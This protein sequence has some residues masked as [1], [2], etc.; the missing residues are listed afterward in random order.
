[1]TNRPDKLDLDIKRAGRLDKKIPL[2]YAQTADEVEA[3]VSAQL[4]KH[5]L[6]ST[7]AFPADRAV[8]SEP[9]LGLSNADFEAIVLLA[10]EIAS[11]ADGSSVKVGREQMVQAIADYLPS[12]DVK[13]LEYMEL[14]AVFE[15]SNRKML[16]LK[17]QTM[18]AEELQ[19][20]LELLRLECGNR[21]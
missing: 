5:R 7:L 11:G 14:L 18:S 6:E 17:Y 19:A 10:A 3:V 21:R 9:M 20:R 15:A 8:I 12:R 2:L 16:P 13:M 4:R 1:M